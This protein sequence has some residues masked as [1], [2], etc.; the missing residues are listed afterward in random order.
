MD[1]RSFVGL[2]GGTTLMN[3]NPAGAAGAQK[4]KYYVLENFFLKNGSQPGRIN[5]F[6]RDAL[7]P[8]LNKVHA[9]PKIFMEALV[10]PHMPQFALILGLRSLEELSSLE[11]ALWKQEELRK[12]AEA[13]EAHPAEPPYEHTTCSLLEATDYSPE[14]VPLDPAPKTPRIFELR[15]YHSPTYRQLKAL[16]ERFAG[17]E[18]KIFARCGVHPL[19]YSSTYFGDNRP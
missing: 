5:D 3:A 12:A 2:M 4:T 18:I 10:A 13:W 14:I 9:G 17:P 11:T 6:M 1:R 19:F 16:H 15:T 7:L 8:A